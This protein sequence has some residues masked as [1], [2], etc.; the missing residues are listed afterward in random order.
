M[1]VS[2]LVATSD[3]V[4]A[5]SSRL[6]KIGAL[7]GLLRRLSPEEVQIGV[8]WLAGRLR[9]GRIGFGPSLVTEARRA[10]PSATEP[11]LTLGEADA[12][13]SEIARISGPGSAG[14]RRAALG[15]LLA[16]ATELERDFF[17]RLL[18]GELRQGAL[19][20]VMIEAVARAAGLPPASL[21]RAV[22]LAGDAAEVAKA[23]LLEGAFGLQR[24]SL[25]LFRP[26]QPMLAQ[27][28]DDVAS[29]LG[30]LRAA[31]LEWKLD[32]ARVQV[33]KAGDEVR[34]FSRGLSSVTNAVPEI[35]EAVRALPVRSVVLDGEAIAFRSDGA[36]LPFQV[37]M[38]RFGRMLDVAALRAEL[39]LRAIFFD[40]LHL[41]GED[42]LDRS[43]GERATALRQVL[44]RSLRV[45]RIELPTEAEAEAFF[46]DAL[47]RGHEGVMAKSLGAPYEAGRRG[48][49]WLKV[50]RAHTLD[51]VVLAVEWGS[52]RRRGLLSNL[53]L[54]AR[55]PGSGG[56]V[57]LGKTFKGMTDEV[58]AWQTQRLLEL[59]ITRD[60]YTVYV[61]PE[62]VV[63][64]AFDGVQASPQYP[65]G[66]ALRF[67][68]VKRYRPDK[69]AVDASTI[70]EVRAIHA[71]ALAHEAADRRE[72]GTG[73]EEA[74]GDG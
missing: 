24:F 21:R 19:E 55:D 57:M 72:S 56:F 67:A 52:G 49:S 59:E 16:R 18:V 14:Q 23:A 53:H 6:E 15:G 36:P 13:F 7:A 3:R 44:D 11:T 37:T 48:S 32:G 2:D 28:A 74:E 20:A 47:A 65:G 4:A 31:A 45:P 25:Q 64:I 5:T 41:D 26:V 9:Q 60:A 34:V 22:M 1:L 30:E 58:L 33:H 50:K 27:A 63:E 51:L 73:G 42:L 40:V 68:R 54:G 70:D 12:V 38:R 61:R 43:G 10:G 69:A 71:G 46:A 39:P 35:V 17:A 29:A 62:L 8:D 66:V